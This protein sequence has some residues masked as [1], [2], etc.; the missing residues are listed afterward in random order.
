MIK[1]NITQP[2]YFE[3]IET[4]NGYLLG[5][6]TLN[7]LETLNALTLD[8]V[9]LLTQRLNIWRDNPKISVVLLQAEGDRAFSAGGDLQSL[10]QSMLEQPASDPLD[11]TSNQ[12][13]AHFFEEEYRLDY[14]IHLYPKPILSWGHGIIMGGGIG[15]FI[16]ASHRV[17]TE[18]ARL[19]MPEVAIGL[20]P[21]V[22]ASWFLNR[23][24]RFCGLFM[25][26]TGIS[27]NANDAIF[28]KFADYKINQA[29]KST[30]INRLQVESWDGETDHIRL[31]KILLEAETKSAAI[32]KELPEQLLTHYKLIQTLC[33]APTLPD[34]VHNILALKTDDQWLK[35]G[36]ETLSA[37]SPTSIYLLYEMQ[38]RSKYLSLAD[39]FRLE[40]IVTLHCALKDE[41]KEGIRALIIDKDRSP[42]WKPESLNAVKIEDINQFF[43]H[44][45]TE[46]DH[47]LA[48]L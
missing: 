46:G 11:L 42:K 24:P 37:G 33:S 44:H 2:I 15:V 16:G 43:E 9:R 39:V 7:S 19:A 29:K 6:A 18:T 23:T 25:A 21:D 26:L 31:T 5:V 48:D 45:W 32:F 34:I 20:Y 27:I 3:E 28:A 17:V 38:K 10:Y 47:P 22:G 40:F 12:Y 35:R 13:A 36:Q 41:F 14:L 30:V 8:M 1:N 4:K